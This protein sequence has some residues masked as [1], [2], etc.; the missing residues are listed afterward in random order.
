[1]PRDRWSGKTKLI[2]DQKG[3]NNNFIDF[4]EGSFSAKNFRLNCLTVP[5]MA[6]WHFAPKRNWYL[7]FGPYL[8]ILLNARETDYNTDV[9]IF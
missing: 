9:K 6:S 5:V 8:G 4:Q 1:V 7:D 3:W 2:Y